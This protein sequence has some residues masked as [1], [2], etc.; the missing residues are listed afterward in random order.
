MKEQ[1]ISESRK[2]KIALIQLKNSKDREVNLRRGL[3]ALKKAAQAGANIVVF[4]ELSFLPFLPQHPAQPGFEKWA[5]SVPGPTTELMSQKAR[6]YG[7]VIVFNLLEKAGDKTYD[8]SPVID[9]DG[10]IAGLNRMVQVLEAPCFHEK[11]YYHP[12]DL[13]AGVF[14]T[15]FGKIGVAI[16]YDRHFPEYMR[17]LALK[18]AELV[19]VPQAG[20][21]GEWPAGIFEAE[22]QVASFQNGY[23][24]ALANRL[25]QEDCVEFEGGSFITDSSGRILA[26]ARK[27]EEDLLV[28]EIDLNEV[29][30]SC[31][32]RYFRLDRRSNSL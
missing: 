29:Y 6:E 3:E 4:P 1:E 24:C 21:K 22:L 20:A 9:V 30:A 17:A 27:G 13:G 15:A 23:F 10:R 31:A 16:C 26:Q 8:S 14:D 2:I 5:E 12:G 18:G 25:G 19:V 7:L 11:G 28:V 32:R